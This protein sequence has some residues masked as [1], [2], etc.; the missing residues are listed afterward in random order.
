MLLIAMRNVSENSYSVRVVYPKAAQTIT[1]CAGP[2]SDIKCKQAT[3]DLLKASSDVY[4]HQNTA[5]RDETHLKRDT[6]PFLHPATLSSAHRAALSLY[7]ALLR[8]AEGKR[9]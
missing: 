4:G 2:L 1:P 9:S 7:S 6:V 8:E 3:C 5:R